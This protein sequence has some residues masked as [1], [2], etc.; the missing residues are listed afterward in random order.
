MVLA[1]HGPYKA[2]GAAVVLGTTVPVVS[3]NLSSFHGL[4]EALAHAL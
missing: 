1:A 3:R 2:A 4:V